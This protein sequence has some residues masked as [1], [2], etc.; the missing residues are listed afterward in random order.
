MSYLPARL[1]NGSSAPS[2]A[3]D[4]L[5]ALLWLGALAVGIWA[6]WQAAHDRP[7]RIPWE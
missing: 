4:P 7:P 5:T 6:L 1:G 2:S 3:S